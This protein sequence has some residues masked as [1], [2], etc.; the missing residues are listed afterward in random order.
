[1]QW[2]FPT[3]TGDFVSREKFAIAPVFG[4]KWDLDGPNTFIAPIW[5]F[6]SSFGDIDNGENRDDVS[7][8]TLQPYLNISTK[9]WGWPIDFITFYETQEIKLNFEDGTTKESGD[10]F[11]PFEMEVGKMLAPGVVGS[12][13]FGFPI[14]KSDGFDAY[15]WFVEFRIGFFF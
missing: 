3:G 8:L 12:I 14:Y 6:R 11:I 4:W 9:D 5:R 15:D 13:D 7:E 2:G 1:M 10:W